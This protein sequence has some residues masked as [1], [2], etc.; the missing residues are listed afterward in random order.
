MSKNSIVGRK[1]MV[2]NYPEGT[3]NG[4]VGTIREVRDTQQYRLRV[5]FDE[6]LWQHP[7]GPL[8]NEDELLYLNN[9]PV[10]LP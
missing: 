2:V 5:K 7:N 10:V 9:R 6:F 3:F 1:V 4:M 8:F